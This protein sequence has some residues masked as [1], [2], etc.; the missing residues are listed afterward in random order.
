M[1][2]LR[3]CPR[4]GSSLRTTRTIGSLRYPLAFAVVLTVSFCDVAS[5]FPAPREGKRRGFL[6]KTLA[7]V[8]VG[9]PAAAGLQ[10]A[11]ST[12]QERRKMRVVVEGF[13]RL[14][15]SLSL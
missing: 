4:P 14:C 11:A 1:T 3:R 13:G 10:Y 9:V 2:L 12:P 15:R 5:P 8:S 7:G 6:W